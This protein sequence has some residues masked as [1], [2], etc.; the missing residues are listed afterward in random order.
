MGGGPEV[1][2]TVVDGVG[3][4]EGMDWECSLFSFRVERQSEDNLWQ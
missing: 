1:L 3:A 2:V 4:G